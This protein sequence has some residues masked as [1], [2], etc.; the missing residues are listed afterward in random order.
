M[1]TGIRALALLSLI[2]L[3]VW[4]GYLLGQGN[5]TQNLTDKTATLS[6]NAA[7]PLQL[8]Q[9]LDSAEPSRDTMTIDEQVDS[10]IERIN[11]LS[12]QTQDHIIDQER[13]GLLRD[14]ALGLRSPSAEQYLPALGYYNRLIPRDA[15]ALLLESAFYQGRR[16]LREAITPLLAAAQFPESNEQLQIIQRLQADIFSDLFDEHAALG[17]WQGLLTYFDE[18]LLEDPNNDRARLF[19]AQAQADSGDATSAINTL[20]NTGTEAGVT[21]R[22]INEFRDRLVR[23]AVAPIRFRSEG[24]SL[25]ANATLNSAP[26]ELLVDTGAT[27]TALATS[28]LRSLGA[29][30]LNETAQVMTAAGRITTQLYEV[31]E[32]IVEDTPFRDLVVLALDNPPASWDGLLGMDLLRDM[33]VDLSNQ[34][35][36]P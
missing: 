20:D 23:A 17:D 22:E 18:L 9:A 19:M 30:P 14:L 2:G 24:N 12:I 3:S 32:L 10:L 16:R 6:Q 26:V 28:V 33:N 11:T 34:L 25:I 7:D 5:L 13:A 15:T 31:P 36:T 27:K 21:Q 29:R 4:L 35:D 8:Q 1:T